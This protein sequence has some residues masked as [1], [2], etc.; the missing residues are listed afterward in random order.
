MRAERDE[1][2]HLRAA[3]RTIG[4]DL[5]RRGS[6]RFPLAGGGRIFVDRPLPFLC[7]HRALPGAP[8]PGTERLIDGEAS[9][10]LLGPGASRRDGERL[11]EALAEPLAE[12]FGGFI[13][14]EI[15]GSNGEPRDPNAPPVFSGPGFRLEARG[16][17][18]LSPL[19]DVWK[20]SLDR[21]RV[22]KQS[23]GTSLVRDDAWAPPAGRPLLAA[24][25][26]RRA[27]CESVGVEVEP[28]F[29]SAGGD[30]FADVLRRLRRQFSTALR[31]G[32]HHFA[33]TRTRE[34]PVSYRALG[35]RAV[36]RPVLD[37]DAR[38]AELAGSYDL[39][40]D[41]T[42]VNLDEA[43]RR[44]RS[45]G[46]EHAPAFYYRPLS[47]APT[48]IKRRLF[49][50]SADR[51]EDPALAQLLREKQL[52]I[53][54]EM[55]MLLDRGTRRFLYGSLQIYGDVSPRLRALAV[56]L[57]DSLPPTR[58]RGPG[59]EK[60][61]AEAFAAAARREIER[62]RELLRSFSSRVE[63]RDDMYSGLMVT[64]GNLLIGR[65]LTVSKRRLE[66]LL[67]HEIGTHALTY[68]NGTAQRFRLLA[69]GLP[70]YDELQE[71][72]AVLAEHLVGG[73]DRSRLRLLAGRVLAAG[74][75]VD[76][77][78]FVEVFRE[79]T[80]GRGFA[81]RTAFT[82]TARV[83]RG[84][85]LTKDA[86]YLRGLSELL[87]YLGEGGELEPLFVG[88]IAARHVPIVRE[89]QLRGLVGSPAVAPLHLRTPQARQ[90]ISRLRQ[91]LGV[92]D[93]ARGGAR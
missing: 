57:I 6:L 56:E 38:L 22:L 13:V 14:L 50:V 15:W 10:L 70:G 69:V 66:A 77:A 64:R 90:R 88:K 53:D 23:A 33:V 67:C 71:G 34:A 49:R 3:A 24:A 45:A 28:A 16:G 72:L 76:G 47:V 80:R 21:V 82:V 78:G 48:E 8:D 29:R 18:D 89:L 83:F 87:A 59:R 55:T 75:M 11:V 42:P 73:L 81:R 26:W 85:G 32:L 62:Y 65:G 54:R 39:L 9:F 2:R 36:R 43:W 51:V 84:G 27:G 20:R 1:R 46:H 19:L 61:D 40:L 74:M 86:V 58:E 7:V 79:L 30:I 12:R 68:H 25:R 5:E 92:L 91:G 37:L 63:I 41:V 60:L 4:D 17:H 31:R 52:A 44:F 35:R 93:L